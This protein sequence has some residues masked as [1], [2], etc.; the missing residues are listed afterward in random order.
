MKICST[1]ERLNYIMDLKGIK[2]ADILRKAKPLCEK[3]NVRLESNDLSQYV[4]GKV[5]PSQKR[6]S[7]LADVLETNEVWLMGYDVP[8]EKE[9]EKEI[10]VNSNPKPDSYWDTLIFNTIGEVGKTEKDRELL[11]KCSRLEPENKK[12]ILKDVNIL[13]KEQNNYFEKDK[14]DGSL[15]DP[16]ETEYKD[17][18]FILDNSKPYSS[19][20]VLYDKVDKQNILSDSEKEV[21]KAVIKNAI[22]RYEDN[23]KG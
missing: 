12:E 18:D 13:L 23:K 21:I 17:N 16:Y 9:F 8:M 7:I 14:I 11:Y 1:A 2:Q 6:L 20:N 5:E 19:L 15:F 22:N 10:N 4:T 3:Y